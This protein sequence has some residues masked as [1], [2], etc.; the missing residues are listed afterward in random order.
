MDEAETSSTAMTEDNS[1]AALV[2]NL[3]AAISFHVDNAA[4]LTSIVTLLQ[5]EFTH[6]PVHTKN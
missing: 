4:A 3:I 5:V 1:E 2:R 6:C